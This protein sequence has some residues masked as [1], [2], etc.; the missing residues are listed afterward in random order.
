METEHETGNATLKLPELLASVLQSIDDIAKN[1]LSHLRKESTK[2]PEP[3][4]EPPAEAPP[5]PEPEPAFQVLHKRNDGFLGRD[6]ELGTLLL[7]RKPQHRGRMALV[8]LG[9][10]GKTELAVEFVYRIR[11]LSP[12]CSIYWFGPNELVNSEELDEFLKS[13]HD[14]SAVLVVDASKQ[15]VDSPLVHRLEKLQQFQGTILFLA[16]GYQTARLLADPRQVF[17]LHRLGDDDAVVLLKKSITRQSLDSAREGELLSIVH[18]LSG[19]PRAIIQIASLLNH[20]GMTVCQFIDLYGKDE[21][22]QLRLLGRAESVVNITDDDSVIARGTFDV[23][24]FR[25]TYHDASGILFQLYFL[26]GTSI[27]R[28]L[29]SIDTLDLIVIMGVLKGHFLVFERDDAYNIHPMV[30]LALKASLDGRKGNDDDYDVNREKVWYRKILNAFSRK[31][32][33]VRDEDR[34]WWRGILDHIL[35]EHDPT[36]QTVGYSIASIYLKESKYFFHKGFF[37]D[38]LKASTSA[39]AHL[40]DPVPK[41]NLDVFEHHSELLRIFGRFSEAHK[42]LEQCLEGLSPVASVQKQSMEANLELI[43]PERGYESAVQKFGNIRNLKRDTKFSAPDFW[44]S[45]NG[46]AMAL[47]CKGDFRE[48]EVR[49]RGTLQAQTAKFGSSHEDVFTTAHILVR[50]LFKNANFENATEQVNSV[51]KGREA[52]LGQNHPDTLCSK[53]LKVDILLSISS[54]MEDFQ[55]AEEMLRDYSIALTKAFSE[56]HPTVL[57]CQ[58][59]RAQALLSQGKFEDAHRMITNVLSAREKGPWKNPRVHP[60]TLNSK[61][62]LAELL[63]VKEGYSKADILSK[64]VLEE[65]TAKLTDG[66]MNGED[67][68][69]DQLNSLQHRAIVL[70]LLGGHAEEAVSKIKLSLEGRQAILRPNHPDTLLNLTWHGEILRA[71]LSHRKIPISQRSAELKTIEGFHKL[72]ID[73]LAGIF[74]QEHQHTLQCITNLAFAKNERGTSIGYA[75]AMALYEQVFST[76]MKTIGALHPETLKSKIRFA[77]AIRMADSGKAT[78]AREMWKEAKDGF[79]TI[80]GVDGYGT[81]MAQKEYEDFFV[82]TY[83]T[84]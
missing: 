13:D 60:D 37:S 26:G 20:T 9:G 3:I 64:V 29:F 10:V 52:L 30:Y 22:L 65:R 53:A 11:D 38:A 84:P 2:E 43:E 81:V 51:I 54:V 69:P 41:D 58:T 66:T 75:E 18:S 14:T 77:R 62:Q 49:C 33:G 15:L 46:Y 73:G 12:K 19:L 23:K 21:K 68:H 32:P 7:M 17:E 6:T 1:I 63:R 48:A 72:A 36:I 55:D 71:N 42:V 16:R 74:G 5:P 27:P 61:H 8:G 24:T 78:E 79:A 80:F 28:S 39:K 35:T 34:G 50:A 44:K 70:S 67:F 25:N 82:K 57:S 76:N 83:P 59:S 40:P 56:N 47:I 45:E 4:P 31:Y